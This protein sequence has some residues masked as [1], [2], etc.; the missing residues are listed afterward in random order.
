MS[1]LYI[2]KMADTDFIAWEAELN[3]TVQSLAQ[4]LCIQEVS[5]LNKDF[6]TSYPA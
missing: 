4:L 6:H 2:L 1:Y 5:G 3:M